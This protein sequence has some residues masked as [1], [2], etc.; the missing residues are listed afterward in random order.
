MGT[1]LPKVLLPLAGLPLLEWVLRSAS[2]LEATRTSAILGYSADNVMAVIGDRD[3]QVVAKAPLLGPI[4]A[5][6]ALDELGGADDADT[7]LVFP[8]D[9]PMIRPDTLKA[10][11]AHR[12]VTSAADDC[13]GSSL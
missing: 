4:H 9:V 5:L 11:V 3:V 2:T 13:R 8:A 12:A 7:I 10:L 1:T 6:T